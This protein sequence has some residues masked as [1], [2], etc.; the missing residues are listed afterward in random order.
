MNKFTCGQKA[1][2]T[3]PIWKQGARGRL[4]RGDIVDVIAVFNAKDKKQ[5]VSIKHETEGVFLDIVDPIR[6]LLPLN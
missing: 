6:C 5:I 2:V 1:K 4:Q 3:E